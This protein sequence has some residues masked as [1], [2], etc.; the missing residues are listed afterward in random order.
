[1]GFVVRLFGILLVLGFIIGFVV[2]SGQ[3][4]D[5]NARD[6]ESFNGA[7]VKQ[8]M[9]EQNFREGDLISI[10]NVFLFFNFYQGKQV[11]LQGILSINP[12]KNR[13]EISDLNCPDRPYQRH[14]LVVTMTD[15]TVGSDLRGNVEVHGALDNKYS[16]LFKAQK[17]TQ[18]DE[19]SQDAC[20]LP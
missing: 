3:S 9:A 2:Y 4:R 7:I 18:I 19:F 12:K 8:E 16:D 10:R 1:M 5:S 15:K 14:P 6:L 11:R 17:I 20:T 13:L